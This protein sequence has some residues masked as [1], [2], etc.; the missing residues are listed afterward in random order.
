MKNVIVITTR[1]YP[2]NERG[3]TE[4][5]NSQTYLAGL[6]RTAEDL[7]KPDGSAGDNPDWATITGYNYSAPLPIQYKEINEN[8]VVY[9]APCILN[10]EYLEIQQRHKYVSNILNVVMT[11]LGEEEFIGYLFTHDKD[12]SRSKETQNRHFS[13]EDFIIEEFNVKVNTFDGTF[14]KFLGNDGYKNGYM[15]SHGL[16][17]SEYVLLFLSENFEEVIENVKNKAQKTHNINL[18]DL[19]F[20]FIPSKEN[21]SVKSDDKLDPNINELVSKICEAYDNNEEFVSYKDGNV[22]H[23]IK[24]LKYQEDL[25]KG[26]SASRDEKD[27]IKPI[28]ER[29]QD[30]NRFDAL[31]GIQTEKGVRCPIIHF[32]PNDIDDWSDNVRV[33]RYFDSSIWNF[34]IN[35]SL[36]C[37]E[38]KERIRQVVEDIV[39]YWKNHYYSVDI[40]THYADFNLRLFEQS[41][42]EDKHGDHVAPFPFHSESFMRSEIDKFIKTGKYNSISDYKWRFLLIDD[43]SELK[44]NGSIQL[45]K[46]AIIRDN[47]RKIFNNVNNNRE[48]ICVKYGKELKAEDVNE[49]TFIVIDYVENKED[50]LKAI[51]E[52]KYDIILLDYLLD[53]GNSNPNVRGEEYRYGYSILK[54]LLKNDEGNLDKYGPHK[55]LYFMFISAYTTA[56]NDMLLAQALPKGHKNWFIMQGACPTNTPY[57]FRYNLLN[58]MYKRIEACGIEKL[59]IP[60]YIDEKEKFKTC[61]IKSKIIDDIYDKNNPREAANEKFDKVLSLLYHYKN[62]LRDVHNT[63]IIFNSS[64]SVL[65]TDFIEK[66]PDLGGFLEH[67][68]QLVYL[69]AFGTVRQW[70]EMWEEYQFIKSI[71]GPQEHIERYIFKLKNNG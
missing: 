48:I 71:V 46:S 21:V 4:L 64:G 62:L 65:A 27:K 9:V 54:D 28:K 6:E 1:R 38:L 8:L 55:R 44:L 52:K 67:L 69:T 3:F 41:Y 2:Y 42:L 12:V 33:I 59:I 18:P 11:H 56:V 23:D 68:M 16:P 7:F 26:L 60:D 53:S 17:L 34:Y 47:F 14:R 57:L 39:Y 51:K 20:N 66:N 58:L 45:N 30:E 13:E 49:K 37:D 25:I 40:S 5:K 43:K 70:P 31:R 35:S 50:A 32:I 61:G 15:F 10:T 24:I 22:T 29:F 63:Q 36:C 19:D